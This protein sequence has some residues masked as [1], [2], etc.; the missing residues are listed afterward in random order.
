MSPIL[1][2]LRSDLHSQVRIVAVATLNHATILPFYYLGLVT[3]DNGSGGI[4]QC[5]LQCIAVQAGRHC[6]EGWSDI[7]SLVIIGMTSNT[8]PYTC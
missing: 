7:A 2:H 4:Q 6:I 1:C 5:P 8:T 3:A